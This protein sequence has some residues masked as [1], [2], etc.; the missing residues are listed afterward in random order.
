MPTPLIGFF[1]NQLEWRKTVKKPKTHLDFL[2]QIC[3][4]NNTPDLS[5]RKV[6]FMKRKIR[7]AGVSFETHLHEVDLKYLQNYF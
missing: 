2:T 7:Y 6:Y 5:E 3:Y 1:Q 4:Y